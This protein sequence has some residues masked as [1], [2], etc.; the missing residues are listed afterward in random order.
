[1]SIIKKISRRFSLGSS[2]KSNKHDEVHAFVLNLKKPMG[3]TAK[4]KT[5]VISNVEANGQAAKGG[6]REGD[7]ITSIGGIDVSDMRELQGAIADFRNRVFISCFDFFFFSLFNHTIDRSIAT[8]SMCLYF[9]NH[10][11]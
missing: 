8:I 10:R 9:I 3:L 7:V 6:V 4:D 2:S 5:L 1:M 11:A